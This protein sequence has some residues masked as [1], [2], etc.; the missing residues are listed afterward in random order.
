M[1][2]AYCLFQRPDDYNT[3]LRRNLFIQIIRLVFVLQS[4]IGNSLMPSPKPHGIAFLIQYFII[5]TTCRFGNC[6]EQSRCCVIWTSVHTSLFICRGR[7]IHLTK[8]AFHHSNFE[9]NGLSRHIPHYDMQSEVD[10]NQ[11]CTFT[12]KLFRESSWPC[13]PRLLY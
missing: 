3:A 10:R 8:Y 13:G 5:W 12:W 9:Q 1:L 6:R 4:W 7:P 2:N 11:E